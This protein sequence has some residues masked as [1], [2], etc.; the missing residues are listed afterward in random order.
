M[1]CKQASTHHTETVD[2]HKPTGGHYKCNVDDSFSHALSK[3]GIGICIREDDGRF[4]LAKT[5]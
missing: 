4:V 5:E 2:W 1:I 3:V